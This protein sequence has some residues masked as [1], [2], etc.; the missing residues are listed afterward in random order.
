MY[1]KLLKKIKAE[2][3]LIIL[4]IIMLAFVGLP[5]SSTYPSEKLTSSPQDPDSYYASLDLQKKNQASAFSITSSDK[6]IDYVAVNILKNTYYIKKKSDLKIIGIGKAKLLFENKSAKKLAGII[7]DKALL[8]S[9]SKNI[10]VNKLNA[11]HF[12]SVLPLSTGCF[13][14]LIKDAK[15]SDVCSELSTDLPVSIIYVQDSLKQNII[16][17]FDQTF[18]N[19]YKVLQNILVKQITQNKRHGLAKTEDPSL[20]ALSRAGGK[21]VK[22]FVLPTAIKDIDSKYLQK[23]IFQLKAASVSD[24]Y[25]STSSHSSSASSQAS[26]QNPVQ[27]TVEPT[28]DPQQ[29]CCT[30]CDFQLNTKQ[31]SEAE[32]FKNECAKWLSSAKY[33]LC[34]KSVRGIKP[35]WIYKET[36]QGTFLCWEEFPFPDQ[37]SCD[38][39][40]FHYSYFG[41][42]T[43][44]TGP[45]CIK[46]VIEACFTSDI[47]ETDIEKSVNIEL[48]SCAPLNDEESVIDLLNESRKKFPDTRFQV[49]G[50]TYFGIIGAPDPSSNEVKA[51]YIIHAGSNDPIKPI[52]SNCDDFLGQK[53]VGKYPE[54]IHASCDLDDQPQQISCCKPKNIKPQPNGVFGGGIW[55]KTGDSC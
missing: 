8:I 27:P 25:K 46:S 33:S 40:N 38:K 11:R 14:N 36:K 29:E 21:I 43:N 45:Q 55:V 49:T 19:Y 42:G 1:L 37:A 24:I 51:T 35:E 3:S 39:A 53:C 5:R 31:S 17:K 13:F 15:L 26:D 22:E 12:I 2:F 54:P 7:T 23:H 6:K 20:V 32:Y 28:K 16:I 41:H 9:R 50:P 48:H 47:L 30:H 4:A 18:H 52:R 44:L 10:P 34:R